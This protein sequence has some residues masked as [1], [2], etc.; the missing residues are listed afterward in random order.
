MHVEAERVP[1]FLRRHVEA[2]H[3]TR[4]ATFVPLGAIGLKK[5]KYLPVCAELWLPNTSALVADTARFVRWAGEDLDVAPLATWRPTRLGVN[6]MSGSQKDPA[7][8]PPHTDPAAESGL[9][10]AFTVCGQGETNGQ[11]SAQGDVHFF[12]GADVCRAAGLTQP[13]HMVSADNYRISM[14]AA[15]LLSQ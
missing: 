5:L 15:N 11:L 9:V 1:P 6:Y 14:T 13:E 4:R 3:G 2:W 10:M 7:V 8:I 12:L